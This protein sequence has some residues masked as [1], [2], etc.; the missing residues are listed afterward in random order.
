V[1][2]GALPGAA[3]RA[4]RRD[5]AV[6]AAISGTEIAILQMA[7]SELTA[8]RKFTAVQQGDIGRDKSALLECSHVLFP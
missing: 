8:A 7:I 5:A 6:Y 4:F 2:H 1:H 3:H